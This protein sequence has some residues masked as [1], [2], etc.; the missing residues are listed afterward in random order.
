MEGDE[1]PRERRG[2][3]KGGK[4]VRGRKRNR[5]AREQETE[6]SER[7]QNEKMIRFTRSEATKF[8]VV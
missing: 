2:E 4:S 6:R 1:R 3:K 8:V 7:T 5:A